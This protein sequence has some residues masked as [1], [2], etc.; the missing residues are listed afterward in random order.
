MP[1]SLC[2]RTHEEVVRVRVGTTNLEQLHQV[3]ELSVNIT[4]DCNGAFLLDVSP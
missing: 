4:A 3:V 2:G 1:L